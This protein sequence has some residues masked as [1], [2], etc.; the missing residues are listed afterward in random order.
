MEKSENL[1]KN[2]YEN[3]I[4]KGY[5]IDDFPELLESIF[6]YK[7]DILEFKDPDP[8]D[9]LDM[10]ED[11]KIGTD[12]MLLSTYNDIPLQEINTIIAQNVATSPYSNAIK[13]SYKENTIYIGYDYPEED[14]SFEEKMFSDKAMAPTDTPIL[15]I[16]LFCN[17]NNYKRYQIIE[18][19]SSD[20]SKDTLENIIYNLEE[21]LDKLDSEEETHFKT[22]LSDLASNFG[23]HKTEKKFYP[24]YSFNEKL[25]DIA[26][27]YIIPFNLSLKDGILTINSIINFESIE[28][29]FS[30][31]FIYEVADLVDQF[32][33]LIDLINEYE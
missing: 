1:Y 8:E 4:E 21:K 28:E 29:E 30:N 13:L 14:L 17:V 18:D 11:E 12:A 33:S 22:Y 27:T 31:N 23:E 20:F 16:T 24:S 5:S 6:S 3:L 2:V 10:Y 19:S 26:K 7:G 9:M 15:D 25:L 32:F